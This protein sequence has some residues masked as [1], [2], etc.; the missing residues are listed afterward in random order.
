MQDEVVQSMKEQQRVRRIWQE[1]SLSI[2]WMGGS[3]R[4]WI[5]NEYVVD[6]VDSV[7]V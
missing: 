1:I 6:D 4:G 5:D 3:V 7:R 2:M